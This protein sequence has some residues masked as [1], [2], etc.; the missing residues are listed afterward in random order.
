[1][2]AFKPFDADFFLG[3]DAPS[4]EVRAKLVE[5]RHGTTRVSVILFNALV[6]GVVTWALW[7]HKPTTVLLGWLAAI[8]L[9]VLML[10][11]SM[12]SYT[13]DRSS[14]SSR[15]WAF[16]FTLG[17]FINGTV[18]GMGALLFFDP[19][20]PIDNILMIGIMCGMTAGQVVTAFAVPAS[21]Y[22]FLV[23][24]ILLSMLMPLTQGSLPEKTL[25]LLW[26]P[27]FVIMVLLARS[28]HKNLAR[29]IR[30][31]YENAHLAE[32]LALAKERA[33]RLALAKSDFLAVMSHEIRTPMHGMLGTT[34]L[35]SNTRLD[36]KQKMY[37]EH[38]R[39]A[40]EYL[41]Q[42]LNNILDFSKIEADKLVLHET[43][44]SLSELVSEVLSLF[45]LQVAR[46]GLVL[47]TA[48][49][50]DIPPHWRGD[51]HRLKQVLVNLLGN[52]CKFTDSGT[53][54][55]E[56][57]ILRQEA[58]RTDFLFR[59]SDTGQGISPDLIQTLFDPF[60]QEDRSL[61]RHSGGTGLGLAIS[62]RLVDAMGG[63]LTV[64]S[65]LG[66]GST[67]SFIL[68]LAP[69]EMKAK[70]VTL[71]PVDEN[72]PLPAARVLLADDSA[73]NRMVVREFLADTRCTVDEVENGQE[74]VEEFQ[75]TRYQVVLMDMRMPVMDGIEAV[76]RI[77]VWETEHE[78]NPA[79]IIMLTASAFESDRVSVIAAGCNA[80]LTKP[81]QKNAL[82]QLIRNSSGLEPATPVGA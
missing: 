26:V 82:L 51:P 69:A 8:A 67:F 37:L 50:D 80:M 68:P 56:I 70:A 17:A 34:E 44:F 27:Y 1:M 23:P 53:I 72:T 73:L 45:A 38:L 52:A 9:V 58:D 76:R 59:V 40:G 54:R 78:R 79:H 65:R 75:I 14:H 33:E 47:E 81:V 49:P 13:R 29:S 30:L 41:S 60:T 12:N 10:I 2:K 63:D 74:A 6:A 57:G 22:A 71:M 62:K 43:G 11:W 25:A 55:L 31:G 19:A 7:T 24:A 5:H 15:E 66:H 35:L 39:S 28:A 77:R 48:F 42:L 18:W 16:R 21:A 61:T 36:S 32:N 46:K 20:A 64:E 3:W 4:E